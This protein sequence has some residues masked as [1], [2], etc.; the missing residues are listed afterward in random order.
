MVSGI[1]ITLMIDKIIL[2]IYTFNVLEFHPIFSLQDTTNNST[3]VYVGVY[4][5]RITAGGS[6]PTSLTYFNPEDNM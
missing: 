4:T 3:R 2:V 6:S 1:I 5:M